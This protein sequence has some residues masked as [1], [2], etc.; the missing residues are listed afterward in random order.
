MPAGWQRWRHRTCVGLLLFLATG[1]LTACQGA[2]GQAVPPSGNTAAHVPS[3]SS[4]DASMSATAQAFYK[5]KTL[6]V[7]VPFG[8]GGGY[9]QWAR[10]LAPFWQKY[11]GVAKVD[12]INV[13][14]G[15]GLIGTNQLYTAVADG[16]TI[17]DTPAPGDVFDQMEHVEGVKFDVTR[18][19]WIGRPDDDPTL[20]V[21]H[22]GSPWTR[23]TDLQ[24]AQQP[25]QALATGKGSTEYNAT[26]MTLNALHIPYHMVAAFSGSTDEKAAFLRGNG[27]I[28]AF[29]ASDIDAIR[30]QSHPVL[31]LS[32]RPSPR[33]PNV[34]TVTDTASQQG[35]PADTQKAL[36]AM[37]NVMDLGH[38]FVAPPGVPE[39]RLNA[40]RRAFQLAL[41]DP[42]FVAQAQKAKLPLG[43]KDGQA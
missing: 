8:P 33:Y 20:V 12:I 40:L 36:T 23:V 35:L 38:A 30:E 28:M 11:L 2:S 6:R 1:A 29:S 7:M 18:F 9:D 31:L 42:E 41:Q 22:T 14:G 21:T 10:L 27:D 39:D 25:L 3:A 17:G 26:V 34:P 37:C 5:G 15:G 32:T 43:Y 4:S 19:S 13:P 16:L 24:K